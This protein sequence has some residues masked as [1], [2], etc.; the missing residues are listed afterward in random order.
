VKLQYGSIDSGSD[1]EVVS[2]HNQARHKD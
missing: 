1:S 2:I